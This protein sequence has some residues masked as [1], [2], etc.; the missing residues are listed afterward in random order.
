[1]KACCSNHKTWRSSKGSN[2]YK[3][4]ENGYRRLQMFV[5]DSNIYMRMYNTYSIRILVSNNITGHKSIWIPSKFKSS[6]II[7]L[8]IITVIHY[9]STY[10]IILWL[11]KQYFVIISISIPI[12]SHLRFR[13]APQIIIIVDGKR[14]PC[15]P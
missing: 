3:I 11:L 13:P 6:I 8:I 2:Y 9:Y 4:Q 12:V 15:H 1:M 7:L 5:P 14:H 10:C